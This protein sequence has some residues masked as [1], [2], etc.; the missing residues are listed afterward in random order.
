M[1]GVPEHRPALCL[2]MS[3]PCIAGRSPFFG[4]G[5]Q[6]CAVACVRGE[7]GPAVSQRFSSNRV[8]GPIIRACRCSWPMSDGFATSSGPPIRGCSRQPRHSSLSGCMPCAAAT[9][10]QLPMK[11]L[12]VH[13]NDLF[14]VLDSA[15]VACYLPEARIQKRQRPEAPVRVADGPVTEGRN[16]QGSRGLGDE[17]APVLEKSRRIVLRRVDQQRAQLRETR[18]KPGPLERGRRRGVSTG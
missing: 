15:A 2:L 12:S 1:A 14:R 9:T 3:L 4:G 5:G 8:D 11:V 6:A 17:P 16:E 10:S 18:R 7:V 13:S